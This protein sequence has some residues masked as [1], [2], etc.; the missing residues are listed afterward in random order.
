MNLWL[1]HTALIQERKQNCSYRAE[2]QIFLLFLWYQKDEKTK[3]FP[4]HF[5]IEERKGMDGFLLS[6][7]NVQFILLLS[8]LFSCLRDLSELPRKSNVTSQT[9]RLH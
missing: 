1:F 5:R 4:N 6:L 7:L 3:V 9:C 2:V 8:D